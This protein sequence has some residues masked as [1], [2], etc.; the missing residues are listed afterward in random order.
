MI[1]VYKY[2]ESSESLLY[3]VQ[4]C[5]KR[6]LLRRRAFDVTAFSEIKWNNLGPIFA[7]IESKFVGKVRYFRTCLRGIM[8]INF[9]LR[10]APQMIAY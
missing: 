7:V 5:T 10:R 6:F 8:L 4:K 3:S 9:P 1:D 2:R